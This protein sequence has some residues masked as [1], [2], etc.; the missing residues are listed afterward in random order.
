MS[1][2]FTILS[3]STGPSGANETIKVSFNLARVTV[4]NGVAAYPLGWTP[5]T[6]GWREV[7]VTVGSIFQHVLL[8]ATLVV[9]WPVLT[10][11]EG[12]TRALIALPLAACLLFLG[13]PLHLLAEL[14]FPIRSELDA[15]GFWPLLAWNRLMVAGGGLMLAMGMAIFCVAVARRSTFRK[16]A[17]SNEL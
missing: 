2:D 8:L 10:V 13:G 7:S 3:I 5:A 6:A 16:A 17:E 1:D 15:E 14:W 9:A 12:W 11:R 4:V